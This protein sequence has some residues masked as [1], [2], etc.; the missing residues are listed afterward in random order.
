MP[1]LKLPST[2]AM[3]NVAMEP[4]AEDAVSHN[5]PSPFLE[6]CAQELQF[7]DSF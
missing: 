4:E 1:A 5:V 6:Q 3:G 7:H 2:V